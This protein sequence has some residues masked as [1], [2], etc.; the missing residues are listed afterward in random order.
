MSA[1]FPL[2]SNGTQWLGFTGSDGTATF[3]V[4]QP[5]T[6]GLAIPFN[7]ILARDTA[8]VST[9]DLIFTV[10]TSPDAALATYWGHMPDT[11]TAE[12]GAVFE[13]PKLWKELP[14][15]SGV[16]QIMKPGQCLTQRRGLTAISALVKRRVDH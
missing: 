8:K 11:V 3:N 12:N 13:R 2:V 7:A 9:L 4:E 15:T 14:S 1:T 6:V 16:S 5:D 10:L